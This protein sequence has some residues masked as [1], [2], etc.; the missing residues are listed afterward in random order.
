MTQVLI[1]TSFMESSGSSANSSDPYPHRWAEI[2][3][4]VMA[5]LT[6]TLPF[7]AIA[8][9]SSSSLDVLPTTPYS[10]PRSET[11]NWKNL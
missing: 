5:F 7:L 11:A 1:K 10:L 4:T 9:Y 2:I 8:Y 6:L 3:G